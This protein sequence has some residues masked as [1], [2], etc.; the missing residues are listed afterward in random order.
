[1]K[2][3]SSTEVR[4]N[5]VAA[6]NYCIY[7]KILVVYSSVGLAILTFISHC[8]ANLQSGL[9]CYIPKLMSIY[10]DLE[11]IKADVINTVVFNSHQMTFSLGHSVQ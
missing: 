7:R 11:N 4:V 1:M 10:D 3:L 9:Y 5:N 6:L 8:S 2:L